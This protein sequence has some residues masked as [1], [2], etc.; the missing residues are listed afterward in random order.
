M[1]LSL[2]ARER[3][4]LYREYAH[5][6]LL[7]AEAL[8]IQYRSRVLARRVRRRPG[9]ILEIGPGH[10]GVFRI[11]AARGHRVHLLDLSTDRLRALPEGPAAAGKVTGDAVA[12]PFAGGSFDSVI[13]AE[14]LEHLPDYRATISEISRALRPGGRLV[15][16]VPYEETLQTIPCPRCLQRFPLNGH[17]HSFT[18]K[19][20]AEDLRAAGL[21]PGRPHI[22][23]SFPAR[24]LW[25]RLRVPGLFAATLLL[26]GLLAGRLRTSDTWML[27]SA[28]KA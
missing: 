20:L 7:P 9:R 3:R 5:V 22:G 15:V 24:E 23:P 13:A 27:F 28:E 1:T 21:R 17:L 19:G 25:K 2:D 10:G 6:P 16:S 11:L 8:L 4:A 12:L 18:E 14:V 26:D